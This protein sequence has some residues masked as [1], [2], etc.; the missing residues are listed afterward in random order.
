MTKELGETLILVVDDDRNSGETMQ[1]I[2]KDTGYRAVVC[3]NGAESVNLTKTLRPDLILLNL[4]MPIKFGW[5]AFKEIHSDPKTS[6][7]KVLLFSLNPRL[8]G[9]CQ[10]EDAFMRS[11]IPPEDLLE[12]IE[13]LLSEDSA[14]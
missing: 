2:L 14:A 3:G 8:N 1:G 9:Q 4:S 12:T 11:A 13:H 6:R 7:I 10:D 5:N